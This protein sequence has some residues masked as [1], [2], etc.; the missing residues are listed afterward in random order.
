[1]VS[2]T[3]NVAQTYGAACI[4]LDYTS[5]GVS[6][7][8]AVSVLRQTPDGN[9][10]AVR[11]TP[12][13][14]SGGQAIIWDDELPLNVSVTYLVTAT[15][16]VT[17]GVTSGAVIVTGTGG[18][19]GWL[20]DPIQP[21]NDV[22]LNMSIRSQSDCVGQTGVGLIAI[23]DETF[24]DAD[25]LFEVVDTARPSVVSFT[26]KSSSTTLHFIAMSLADSQLLETLLSSGR[27][28]LVQLP[29]SYGWAYARYGSDYVEVRDAVKGRLQ[30]QNY[31]HP[32]RVW[33]LPARVV[34]SP[35]SVLANTLTGSNGVGV[36]HATYGQMKASGLT[37][38]Q[39]KA[40]NDTYGQLAQGLGY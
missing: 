34:D 17:G 31:K 25:G 27:V 16:I 35:T 20:K 24:T 22:P 10:V 40:T 9:Q 5:A 13:Q 14:L 21:V 36:G 30:T 39:L 4:V 18:D 37:Y 33:Q 23:D 26:R 38:S 3:A 2:V 29:T 7:F 6:G 28:L 8:G 12:L 19:I 32:Q 11:N 1:M 15:S